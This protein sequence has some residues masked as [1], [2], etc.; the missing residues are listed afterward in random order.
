LESVLGT[1]LQWF[2]TKLSQQDLRRLIWIALTTILV[3]LSATVIIVFIA[4]HRGAKISFVGVTIE[5]TS[6]AMR[7]KMFDPYFDLSLPEPQLRL[8][9]MKTIKHAKEFET[10]ENNFYFRILQLELLI[11]KF[12]NYIDT[13]N[14]TDNE[15]TKEAY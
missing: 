2:S 9:I 4:V 15:G 6:D 1:V 7:L 14:R 12:G 10:L 11:P 5:P 13:R 8:T 3:C